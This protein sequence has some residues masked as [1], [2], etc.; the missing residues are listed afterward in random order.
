MMSSCYLILATVVDNLC[1]DQESLLHFV[2]DACVR[3]HSAIGRNV[4]MN[5]THMAA[6]ASGTH[7]NGSYGMEVNET[8]AMCL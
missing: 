1:T 6:S 2:V 4:S 8:T 3:N 5:G 7:S